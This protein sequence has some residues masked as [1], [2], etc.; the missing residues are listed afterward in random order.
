MPVLSTGKKNLNIYLN[1]N[2]YLKFISVQ[3]HNV[4]IVSIFSLK[5]TS[6]T[7]RLGQQLLSET[8]KETEYAVEE[9]IIHPDYDTESRV[10]DI[11]VLKLAQ[12]VKMSEDVHRICLPPHDQEP[13]KK[14]GYIA[15]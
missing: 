5:A 10:D 11:A 3:F 9:I 13:E 15:G 6:V 12:S 1:N 14:I 7:V 4:W 8:D 2:F